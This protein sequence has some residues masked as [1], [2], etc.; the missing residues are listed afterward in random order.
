MDPDANPGYQN[1]AD[2]DK[3][4]Q[5]VPVPGTGLE[6]GVVGVEYLPAD[7]DIPL[8]QQPA[9]VLA[10]LTWETSA[11]YTSA[12]NTSAFNTSAFNTSAFNTSAFNTSAFNTSAFKFYV[13]R[14]FFLAHLY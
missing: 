1:D 14:R 9:S 4:P 6:E 5:A 8:P 12:F 3:D 13:L 11:F 10:L 2:P 7:D